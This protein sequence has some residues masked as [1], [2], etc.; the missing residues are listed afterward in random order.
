VDLDSIGSIAFTSAIAG[1]E[2]SFDTSGSVTGGNVTAVNHIDG[3]AGGSVSLGNL[4]VTGGLP[5]DEDFSVGIAANGNINVGNVNAANAV[6]FASH[7]NLTTG[8][9][10]AGDGFMGLV[11]GNITTGSITTTGESGGQVYLADDSMF[12]AATEGGDPETFDPSIVLALDPV[13]TGGSITING[14]VTTGLFRAAAGTSLTTQA[15]TA[16]EIDAKALGTATINGLWSSPLV[17]LASSDID[18]TGTGG[19]AGGTDGEVNL[20]STNTTRMLIG[21]GLTGSGYALSNAEFGRISGGDIAI[22]AGVGPNAAANTLVG[23][24]TVTVGA[25]GNI[26]NANGGLAIVG[27]SESGQERDGIMRVAG[28]VVGTGFANSNYLAFATEHFEL[29]AENGS[30]ALSAQGG[31]LGGE[32]DL[33]ADTIH[34]ASLPILLKLQSNATYNGYQ[35]DLNKAA[36][37]QRP[38]GVIRADTLWIE[39]DNLQDVLIQNTGADG[40][41]GTRAGF[42]VR[43]AFINDDEEVAGPPGSINL[44]VNGQVETEGGTL[45]GVDARDALVDGADITP[46]TSNSTINGCPLTGECIIKPPQPPPVADVVD[47]QIDLIFSDPLG[48]SDFGNEDSIDDNEDGDEGANNPI[49]PPQPLFDTRPLIPSSEIDD[50]VSGTGNPALVGGE[51]CENQDENGQCPVNPVKGDSQ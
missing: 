34:V 29:D 2:F 13:P 43:Q 41:S 6:G 45:T 12:D 42:L 44:I 19:I 40:T 5:V 16:D 35:N 14:P 11:G 9:I 21:D 7:G 48:D 17:T 15:I 51:Q 10:N 26:R 20:F 28:D 24:L 47:N 46:F 27:L 4:T 25:S 8:N 30:I 36:T 32:L 33:Y 49:A 18:I 37:V 23:D 3:Q 22:I 31:G 50:P 39:S 1:T 38:D